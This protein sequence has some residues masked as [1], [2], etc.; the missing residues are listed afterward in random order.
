MKRFLFVSIIAFALLLGSSGYA[1][2]GFCISQDDLAL[3]GNNE[4]WKNPNTKVWYVPAEDGKYG[5]VYFGFDNFYPQGGMN[6][7]AE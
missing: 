2:T 3:V 1:C 7:F 5:R 6:H 4:D